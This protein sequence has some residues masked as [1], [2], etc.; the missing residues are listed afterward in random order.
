MKNVY[1]NVAIGG[2][3]VHYK[4]S[5]VTFRDVAGRI[6]G[7]ER[8]EHTDRQGLREQLSRWPQGMEVVM[9]ASFG[10]PWL[11]DL[12]LEVG[13]RPRLSNC[14][15]VEK[16]RQA[17][18]WA[19]TNRKDADL[20][21]L[22]PLESSNWWEVWLAPP[23]V[24]DGRERMR[25]RTSLVRIQTGTKNQIHAVFHRQGIFHDF[26]D[27]FGGQGRRLLHEL[28]K[29]GGGRLRGGALE[30]LRG[31]VRLL[32]HVRGQLAEL[33]KRLRRELER[34]PLARRLD[35]IPGFGL[36]LSHALMAEIGR[37]QRFRNHR[38][39]ASYS[40]LAPISDDTGEQ[41]AG[42]APLGRHL[43]HRGNLT[44]KWAFIEAA[45]GA[46]RS[47]GRWRAM[48]DRVTQAGKKNRNRGYIKVARELVKVVYA[49]WKNG[50]MYTQTPAPRPGS[51]KRRQRR[52]PRSGT[53]QLSQPM[54]AA[55]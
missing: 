40:L 29:D 38:A 32:E 53:G 24:R 55:E 43:G 28:C 30:G 47:G 51:L 34:T 20:I 35:S 9:E 14:Y 41:D 46:V 31:Y 52:G 19:K 6:V 1:A 22:L 8:L 25:H 33:A 2:A 11:S 39:L 49:V 50:T 16:M 42:R 18:G 26:S 12:M 7:R 3:D 44:L 45:H 37:I 54:V 17:R 23:E 36:I 27:L 48:F 15:K 13:L 5:T 4:F 21:S 10:W